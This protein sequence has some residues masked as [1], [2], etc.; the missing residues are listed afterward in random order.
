MALVLGLGNPGT[1]YERTRHNVGARVVE[2]LA[3]RWRARPG[4]SAAEYRAWEARVGDRAAVLLRTKMYM[5]E[6]GAA[7][8][9]WRAR[10][11]LEIAELMVVADDVYLPV[12][13]VRVRP[14][15]SSGGHRGLE[16]VG[17]ALDTWEFAR[18]RI[19]VGQA[20]GEALREHVL[21]EFDEA[22]ESEVAEAVLIAADAVECWIGEGL[23]AAMNRFNRRVGK[24]DSE[25]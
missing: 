13:M 2:A 17:A 5:N 23:L 3:G 7:L 9:A 1:R 8:A 25:P 22:E 19:G 11:P 15:G 6:S 21:D 24:E 14:G 12:G 20:P 16:S 4:E 10:H 18:L